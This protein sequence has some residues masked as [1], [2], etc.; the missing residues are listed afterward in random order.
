LQRRL[1]EDEP[2]TSE[3]DDRLREFVEI[4]GLADIAV[5]AEPIAGEPIRGLD[6]CRK[7]T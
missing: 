7:A 4:H 5:G 1:V 3:L 2:I 6:R